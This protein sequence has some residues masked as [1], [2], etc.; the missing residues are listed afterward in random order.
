MASGFLICPVEVEDSAGEVPDDDSGDEVAVFVGVVWCGIG[1]G[2][3]A[4]FASVRAVFE[5]HLVMFGAYH[6]VGSGTGEGLSA[7]AY[8]AD[9]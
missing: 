1:W 3:F 4:A 5:E 6:G 7:G 9:S 2:G 8:G